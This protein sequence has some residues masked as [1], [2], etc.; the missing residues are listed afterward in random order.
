MIV[1]DSFESNQQLN[2]LFVSLSSGVYCTR[3]GTYRQNVAMILAVVDVVELGGG[4]RG[5]ISE[6]NILEGVIFVIIKN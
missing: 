4:R 5:F 1:P 3:F 2:L 6:H